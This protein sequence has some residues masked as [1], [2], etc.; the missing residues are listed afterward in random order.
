M[1][2]GCPQLT[3]R[4]PVIQAQ[5]PDWKDLDGLIWIDKGK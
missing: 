1:D 4:P 5:E 2:G 3:D